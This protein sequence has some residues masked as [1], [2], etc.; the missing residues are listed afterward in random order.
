MRR[1]VIR[2]RKEFLQRRQHEHVHEAIYT[3]KAQFREAM[4][5]STPL[6]GHL[7]K[8]ALMLKKFSELDDAQTQTLTTTVDDEYA[9]AGTEDPRVLVTTSRNASQKLL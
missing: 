8:D 2:T 3:R 4:T 7:R 6:P 1:S 5:N 9:N